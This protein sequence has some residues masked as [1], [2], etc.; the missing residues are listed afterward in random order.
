MPIEIWPGNPFPLGATYDGK[1]VNFA[2]Y[3]EAATRIDVCLFDRA[4]P[5]RQVERFTLPDH[6]EHVWHGYAAGLG[7]GT[8]YG[9]RVYG[10]Y[11]PKAG[12]RCNPNKLLLD[13]YAKAVSGEVDW[14]EPVFGYTVGHPEQDLARDERDSVRGCPKGVVIADDFDWGDDRKPNIPW[15]KTVI[16]EAHVKGLTMRHP[17]VPEKLRGTYAA[18]AEPAIIEHLVSLGVTSIELLPVH[19]AADDSFLED[20]GLINYWGYNTLGFFAPEQRYS[21][22]KT[23]AGVV[24]EF[25]QMVKALH[26]AGIEVILD[27]VYN[28][29]CEG[30]HLGPTLS[31]KGIDNRAYYWLMP[32]EL[33]YYLDFTGCGNSLKLNHPATVRLVVDSLRYW[34]SEMHVDGFRFDLATVLGRNGEGGFDRGAPFLQIV[35]QDPVLSRAKLIAEPWDCSLG[36]YQVGGFPTPW[37]EWNGRYRDTL[38]RYWKGDENLAGELGYRLTGSADLYE[39][40]RRGPQASVNFVTCHDGF[41]L[42]DLVTYGHKHNEAN[43]EHNRDGADDNQSWNHGVEGETDDAAIIELRE[44]QKRNLLAALFLSQ[45]VPMLSHGDEVSRTQ[46]GNNNTY[47]QDNELSW[48]DWN[49]DDRKRVMLEFTRRVIRLRHAQPVLQRRRY[50]RGQHLWDSDFKDLAW[51][52][53]DGSEMRQEDW[54]KPFVKSVAYVLGG[55]AIPSLDEYGNRILGDSLLILMNAHHEPVVYTLP[56]GDFGSDWYLMLDTA[57]PEQPP[58]DTAHVGTYELKERALAVFRH[59][60]ER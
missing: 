46:R 47:C 52:R 45:G 58:S 26:A 2:V 10:P 11:D 6:T 59:T 3:S 22:D 13:P 42:H 8:L 37:R 44:R 50:F 23:P 56:E 20:K 18:I 39:I 24:R 54:Q 4:D 38:R 48:I 41:T 53:P 51:F 1:G 33:R 16:Y 36:G 40:D 7:A 30:N 28:H 14:S 25:K 49:L 12:H 5:K 15:R 60:P 29:S 9:L 35:A 57:H 19:E 17:G 34:A 55:D 31:L 27:V 21:S 43:G 32:D